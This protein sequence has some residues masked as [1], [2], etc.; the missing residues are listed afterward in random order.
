M[1]SSDRFIVS[2]ILGTAANGLLAVSH[3]FPTLYMAVFNIFQLAWHEM[4]AIH[5]FDKDRDEF[6]TDMMKKVMT[7]FSAICMGII[8]VLPII[9]NWFINSNYF[10]AY[11]NIPIY[12]IASLFNVVIGLL[13]VVYVATKKTSEI[14]KTTIFAAA[15]NIVVHI[16]L[17]EYIGLYAASISTLVGYGLT[18]IYRIID[19]KKY[20][21][22]KYDI[23]Q[24]LGIGVALLICTFIYYL[25]NKV[26]SIIFLP[27]FLAVAYFFNRDTVQGAIKVVDQKIDGKINKKLF[28]VLISL[29]VVAGMAFASLYVYKKIDN[30]PKAIQSEYS[31]NILEIDAENMI[32]FSDFGSAD[33][34]CTGLTYD[35]KDNSFWVGDYGAMNPNEPAVPRI[36]EVDRSLNSILRTVDLNDVLDS[37]ANLQGVTYDCNSDC[38]WLAIGDNVVEINKEGSIV[39]TIELGKYAEY[40]ANGIGYDKRDDSL[41]VLCATQYLLHLSKDGSILG[42]FNFNYS[43]QDH[44]CIDDRFLYVTVGADYQGTN[45]YVCKVDSNEGTIVDLYQVSGAN[46]LE[47]ICIIDDE[48]MITN[49]GLYH[50]DVQ[51]CSYISKYDFAEFR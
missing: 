4:G 49:D 25:D 31:G 9:F 14:A 6:F 5:Y 17:I 33:F 1:N 46:A 15:I 39:G 32:R 34:T 12:L 24:F 13:G 23:K 21:K 41:W 2:F 35:S 16:V 27:F 10:E 20:L 48:L 38:L 19:T 37:T 51:G 11:Y 3:K 26:V 50:S 8:V 36:I 22:I 42:E 7:I 18:M 43:D 44:I 29:C 45:N 30:T 40:R 47:G 28:I